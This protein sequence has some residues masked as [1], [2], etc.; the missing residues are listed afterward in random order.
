MLHPASLVEN[1][2]LPRR[3]VHYMS[4]GDERGAIARPKYE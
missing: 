4:G 2:G 1:H 3:T